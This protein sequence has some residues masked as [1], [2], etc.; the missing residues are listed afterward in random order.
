MHYFIINCII[1]VINWI[2]G[3]LLLLEREVLM[4]TIANPEKYRAGLY[5]RLSNE[6]IEVASGEVIVSKEDE[7]E[8]GIISTQKIFNENFCKERNI[9]IYDHYTDDGVSGATFDRPDFNRMIKDIE[10]KKINM[11]IVKDLSRFGRLSSQIS[12]YLEEY[13][14]EKGVRFIAVNDDIDTG[15]AESSEEITQFKAFFNEWFLRDTS[16]KIRNGKKTRAKE[17]KVMTTYPTY[18]I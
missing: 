5:E 12:Y 4:I 10:N 15:N 1:S 11:V 6:N 8:S 18:R 14:I 2:G 3:N 13:F 9:F 7:L 17:G 16:K